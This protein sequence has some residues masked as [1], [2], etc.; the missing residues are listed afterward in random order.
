MVTYVVE[1]TNLRKCIVPTILTFFLILL[2]LFI[3]SGELFAQSMDCKGTIQSYKLTHP[4]LNCRCVNGQPKCVSGSGGSRGG[5]GLSKQ[6]AAQFAIN[7]IMQ[8][9][10][11]EDDARE[12]ERKIEQEMQRIKDEKEREIARK[13]AWE[14]VANELMRISSSH[15]TIMRDN[16]DKAACIQG[17][18]NI[19]RV[20]M[21]N[22]SPCCPPYVCEGKF[23]NTYCVFKGSGLADTG[24]TSNC[25]KGDSLILRACVFNGTP[26]C[27]PYRCKGKFPNTYCVLE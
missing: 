26:C 15:S 16:D 25:I 7:L 3:N 27:A 5:M 22:G 11:S 10:F 24:L 19:K 12:Q 8:G 21:L 14:S 9:L 18:P 20:C 4:N 1:V 13:K 6:M 2:I 17:D 23:P